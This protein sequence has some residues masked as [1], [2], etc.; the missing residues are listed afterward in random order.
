MYGD[1]EWL[2]LD[3]DGD[4]DLFVAGACRSAVTG[5][6]ARVYWN[7]MGNSLHTAVNARPQS[8]ATFAAST[9][10]AGQTLLGWAPATDAETPA[11]AL[12]YEVA[13]GTQPGAANVVSAA[14]AD[15]LLGNARLAVPYVAPN[16]PPDTYRRNTNGWPGLVLT[17]LAAGRYYWRVRTVDGG[18]AR[19]AWSAEQAFTRTSAGLCDGDLNGDGAV[20]AG[21]VVGA[22]RMVAGLVPTN[23]PLA[24]LTADGKVD[25][26]DAL[27]I[28]RRI[29]GAGPAEYLAVARG[30][31]G[32]GG[33]SLRVGGR[34]ELAVPA[35]AFARPASLEILMSTDDRPMGSASPPVMYR[36]RG[37][38]ADYSGQ[39]VVRTPDS[40]RTPTNAIL[41][42]VGVDGLRRGGSASNGWQR[43]YLR[44]EGT[45][46]GS[47]LEFRIPAAMLVD[48]PDGVKAGGATRQGPRSRGPLPR[49]SAATLEIDTGV[50][51]D[52]YRVRGAHSVFDYDAGSMSAQ[53]NAVTIATEFEA[54]FAKI[55]GMGIPFDTTRDWTNY[56]VQICI[57]PSMQGAVTDTSSKNGGSI[58]LGA[59]TVADS[60]LR[61]ANIAHECFHV[62]QMLAHP[63]STREQNADRLW[64]LLC[65]ACSTWSEA[66]L[67]PNPSSYL[68]GTKFQN[69]IEFRWRALMGLGFGSQV[70]LEEDTADKSPSSRRNGYGSAGLF[71]YL[72]AYHGTNAV[73][74]F[75]CD[76][77]AGASPMAAARAAFPAATGANR[78]ADYFEKLVCGL[79]YPEQPIIVFSPYSAGWPS[80]KPP[81]WPRYAQRLVIESSQ[82]HS[83]EFRSLIPGLGADGYQIMVATKYVAALSNDQALAFSVECEDASLAVMGARRFHVPGLLWFGTQAPGSSR[84]RCTVPGIKPLV[85]PPYSYGSPPVSFVPLIVRSNWDA[86]ALLGDMKLNVGLVRIL[87]GVYELP[88]CRASYTTAVFTSPTARLVFPTFDCAGTFTVSELPASLT[89]TVTRAS[90]TLNTVGED[91]YQNVSLTAWKDGDI[92]VAID[93]PVTLRTN[94]VEFLKDGVIHRYQVD[95]IR[96]YR[97][98]QYREGPNNT[99]LP[100]ATS[101][102]ADGQFDVQLA[103][104][105]DFAHFAEKVILDGTYKTLRLSDR[106]VLSSAPYVDTCGTLRF[107]LKRK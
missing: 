48:P 45:R 79:L 24:D 37:V 49:A 74:T 85:S 38:P 92:P 81:A 27:A 107:W 75:F 29:L 104:A 69:Y 33:G 1:V 64:D 60:E 65:E 12:S 28:V 16:L 31:V 66:L 8:P 84:I 90:Y 11:P 83:A 39:L 63:G 77:I 7:L 59:G 10:A 32:P 47:Q 87:D 20:D 91:L 72:A 95:A 55:R 103:A 101:V 26:A 52:S 6:I 22:R 93:A 73:A 2:D 71:K 19:S 70:Q 40:R 3:D 51:W 96:E 58:T 36:I 86:P 23:V 4:L 106:A 97:L 17:N 102:S 105:E 35:G 44:V 41:L 5:G 89:G 14:G 99:L 15:P 76:I 62:A 34:Y 21:D 53:S 78:H 57:D 25:D 88:K 61:R 42:A 50:L 100:V 18:R 9:P 56:P 68:S 13:V 43:G 46:T 82:N 94:A 98:I 30:E 67:L 54:A 80:H